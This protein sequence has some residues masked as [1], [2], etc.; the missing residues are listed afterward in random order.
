MLSQ[1]WT[2]GSPLGAK[3]LIHRACTTASN[4]SKDGTK[5]RNGNHLMSSISRESFDERKSTGLDVFQGIL[6]R[7]NGKIEAQPEEEEQ[8]AKGKSA[9]A[10]LSRRWGSLCFVR[11]G[12][13]EDIQGQE[14][15]QQ[16][17]Q[18]SPSSSEN[19]LQTIKHHDSNLIQTPI[20]DKNTVTENRVPISH[21]K[22][23]RR[24]IRDS[25]NQDNLVAS[26]LHQIL[27]VERRNRMTSLIL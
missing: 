27:S 10:L 8:S 3:C 19:I 11:G 14:S 23:S 26:S 25:R 20:D 21:T 22:R 6:G 24:S 15:P 5:L 2:P 12:F 16:A 17:E 7:L 4:A 9:A 13:L 1:G 18:K